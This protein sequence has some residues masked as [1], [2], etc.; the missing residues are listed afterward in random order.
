MVLVYLVLIQVSSYINKI[1]WYESIN[2]HDRREVCNDQQQIIFDQKNI[3]KSVE[4]TLLCQ[5]IRKPD[6]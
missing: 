2:V 4:K 6:L 5:P 3:F 1:N